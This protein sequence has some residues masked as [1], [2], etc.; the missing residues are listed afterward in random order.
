M[1][2]N[3]SNR[4]KTKHE[5]LI[6]SFLNSIGL[7]PLRPKSDQHQVSSCNINVLLKRVNMRI[8]DMITQDEFALYFI[9]FSP[10][11]LLEMNRGLK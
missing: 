1:I 6:W 11:L 5:R 10:L 2:S 4:R 3:D 8:T 7:N 9:N